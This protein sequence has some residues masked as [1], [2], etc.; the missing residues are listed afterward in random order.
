MAMAREVDTWPGRDRP[1]AGSGHPPCHGVALRYLGERAPPCHGVALRYFGERAPPCHGVALRY[2]GERALLKDD[3]RAV[4]V[5]AVSPVT[6][7]KVSF[8]RSLL[9]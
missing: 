5:D 1:L 2:F 3:V 7:A 8:E 6:L 4:N 9:A